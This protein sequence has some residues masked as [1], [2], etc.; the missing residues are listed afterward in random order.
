MAEFSVYLILGYRIQSRSRFIQNNKG[1]I[2]IKGTG[3]GYLLGFTAG[4]LHPFRIKVF[5]QGS[6]QSL[7]H[8]LQTVLKA[9]FLQAG[10]FIFRP[11]GHILP[12]GEGEQP[13]ILKHHGKQ[14]HIFLIAVFAYVYPVKK[15]LSFGGIIQPAQQ[16]DKGSLAAAVHA[17]HR[18]LLP[19]FE[20]QIHMAQG[21]G[22]RIRV[23]EGNIFELD[24]VFIILPL[25]HRQ[26]TLI[27]GVGDIKVRKEPFCI[28]MVDQRQLHRTDDTG[29]SVQ[30]QHDAGHI[31]CNGAHRKPPA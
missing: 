17:Y 31:L 1:G 30:Q 23:S 8:P 3:Q 20:F 9:G 28:P 18:Q 25:F 29:N 15:D 7:G 11:G 2:L 14:C 10:S 19:H 4:D 13:E 12:Q 26:G 6:I 21:I 22:F 5:I 16:F 24:A 27:H